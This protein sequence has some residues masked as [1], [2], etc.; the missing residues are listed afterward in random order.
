[1][2]PIARAIGAAFA[3]PESA[4]ALPA[5]PRRRRKL[6]EMPSRWHCPLVGT[7]VTVAEL[8]KLAR[9]AGLDAAEMSDFALHTAAVGCC[10]ERSDFA[11][12]LQRFLD[13]RHAAALARFAKARGEDA[14]AALWREALAAGSVAG[15]LWAA[16][17]HPDL[18]EEG[19][20]AIYGD[21]HMLSHQLGAGAR[22][23]LRRLA[24]LEAGNA[25]LHSEAAALRLGLAEAQHRHD[26]ET[27]ALARR[28]ADAEQR[29]GLLARLE[30]EIDAA[31]RANSAFGTLAQRAE[32]L[33]RRAEALE[34][35]HALAAR[36]AETLEDELA[37]TRAE[38]AASAAALE[39][40]LGLC[41]R[42]AC[43]EHD[44]PAQRQLAGRRVLCI[45]G[46][47]G[48]VDGYRRLAEVNGADFVHHDGG[49]EDSLHRLD[50]IVAGADA[51]VCQAACVS[52]A[53]YWR[54]KDV[55]KKLG[56]PCVFV[57]SS[58][59]TGFARGLA[60]LADPQRG[61][62]AMASRLAQ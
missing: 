62:D 1:M 6:W 59:V 17:S 50:A 27:A 4:P 36:R 38:L 26:R 58:G 47:T 48:L 32:G 8:R 12:R 2:K 51:V 19:G 11:E 55:C 37:E 24:E 56:K 54:I 46:R 18:S 7:C 23:D 10:D 28:L 60:L 57:K 45:G 20:H 5:T 61:A 52:H 21:V 44:C 3:P 42:G 29:A 40:G 13:K 9:R 16:W 30:F 43:G 34:E 25:R 39:S 53:A 15:A 35:R 33:A 22:A 41:D 14:V 49:I 31:R